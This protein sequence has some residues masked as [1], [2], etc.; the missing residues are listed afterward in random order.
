MGDRI[1]TL[2]MQRG[3]RNKVNSEGISLMSS[4]KK[5]ILIVALLGLA[6]TAYHFIT[7]DHQE[8]ADSNSGQAALPETNADGGTGEV[9]QSGASTNIESKDSPAADTITKPES[10]V[11]TKD[12]KVGNHKIVTPGVRVSFHIIAKL[13]DGTV[14]FDSIRDSRPWTGTVGDGSLMP[15]I[16]KGIRG[17]MTGGKRALW[18][19]PDLAFGPNGIKGQIPPNAKIYAEIDL[20]EVY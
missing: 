4:Y 16:D 12:L 10:R 13:E 1:R 6:V 5:L 14:V 3:S 15:G 19:S 11:L 2:A 20:Q 9:S 18:I 8:N 17:M 7:N